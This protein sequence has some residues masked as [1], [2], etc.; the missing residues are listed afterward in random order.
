MET[1]APLVDAQHRALVERAAALVSRLHASAERPAIEKALREFG[2]YAVRHFSRDE[3]CAMRGDCPA[4]SLNA[5]ARAEL[6]GI[7]AAFRRSFEHDGATPAVAERLD[8]ELDAWVGRYI[9]GPAAASL[10]CVK[11]SL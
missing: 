6:I 11:S 3:D 5:T 2:D 7:V 9:P 8:C 10:P 4:L 1:G